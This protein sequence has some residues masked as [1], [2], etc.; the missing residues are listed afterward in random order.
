MS[1][2]LSSEDAV[3]R[4]L[5]RR[6]RRARLAAKLTQEA[7]ADRAGIDYKRW[8]RLEQGNVNPTARTLLRVAEAVDA[9]FFQLVG[10]G[11]ARGR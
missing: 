5:G 10:R 2:G 3:L 9:D 6:I 11:R 7:A 4:E 1:G 8:Q